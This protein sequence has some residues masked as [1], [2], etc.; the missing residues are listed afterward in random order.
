MEHGSAFYNFK[1]SVHST[2]LQLKTRRINIQS[3]PS[4]TQNTSKLSDIQVF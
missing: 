1:D 4:F 3:P 2:I